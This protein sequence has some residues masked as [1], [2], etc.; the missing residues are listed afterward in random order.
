MKVVYFVT[1]PIQY[2]APMLR[3]LAEQGLDLHVVFDH[4]EG[5][6]GY[7]D[8]E[9]SRQITWDVP[10][11]EGYAH[12]VLHAPGKLVRSIQQCRRV[13]RQHRPQAA[14]IH[15]WGPLHSRAAAIAARLEGVPIMLRGDTHLGSLRGA[16]WRKQLH[17][18]A[19]SFAF[20]M[21][22]H[23]LAVGSANRQLYLHYGVPHERITLMPYAVDNAFFKSRCAAA[24]PHRESLRRELGIPAGRPVFLF[25]AKL[26]PHKAPDLL[27]RAA[28]SLHA[29]GG[30]PAPVVLIVGD[31]PMMPELRALASQ[32]PGDTC[33]FLG[34]KNQ[35]ELPPLF[36]LCDVFVLPSHFE[37][38][39][40]VLNEVMVAG[41][42][43]I[44]SDA[45]GAAPDLVLDGVTGIQFPSG[46]QRALESA[47]HRF[48]TDIAF[49]HT[50]GAAA[51]KLVE[52][53]WSLDASI[54]AF[55]K[56]LSATV[57]SQ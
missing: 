3:K 4:L 6:S 52:S 27:I 55:K 50:S 10:L 16:S 33:H 35:T 26:V 37:P 53:D 5:V 41:K 7:F 43:V 11:L 51:L 1:H 31:G 14:W 18:V 8:K 9:F 30:A 47:M 19:F 45:V 48:S 12:E 36:D 21:V 49:R 22:S 46:D 23:F 15:G 57:R 13:L 25:A 56:A 2:Q 44:A 28:L 17:R 42:P 24:H 40:L 34:F 39:G 29:Q 32:L 38:W 54:V 20:K